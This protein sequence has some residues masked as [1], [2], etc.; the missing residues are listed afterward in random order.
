[1]KK[2]RGFTVVELVIV[3]ILFAISYA[4]WTL[5]ISLATQTAEHEAER[6]AAYID[7]VIDK[8]DRMHLSFTMD[9]DFDTDSAGNKSYYITVKWPGGEE[10]HDKS[11]R[12]SAGCR[13]SDNFKGTDKEELV[14]NVI[15]KQ[16]NTGGKITVTDSQGETCYIKIGST[17]GRIRITEKDD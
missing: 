15:S 16:F 14:Y 3:L 4:S 17:E 10:N 9:T 8:A 13:Y 2:R 5:S 6:L 12:A 11:F 7:R 1:M